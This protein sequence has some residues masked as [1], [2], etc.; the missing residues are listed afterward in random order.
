MIEQ[1]IGMRGF[2]ASVDNAEKGV[3]GKFGNALQSMFAN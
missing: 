3:E 2:F 1:S